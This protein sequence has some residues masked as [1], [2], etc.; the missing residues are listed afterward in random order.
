MALSSGSA[1]CAARLAVDR[2][3][4]EPRLSNFERAAGEKL[5]GSPVNQGTERQDHAPAVI[6]EFHERAIARWQLE[7]RG[8]CLG[9]AQ[10][11]DMSHRCVLPSRAP[12]GRVGASVRQRHRA[13]E[14]HGVCLVDMARTAAA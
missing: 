11:P 9:I 10:R 7:R 1:V 4:R 3:H 14:Q 8:F 6:G 2:Q 13:V 5:L 12:Q